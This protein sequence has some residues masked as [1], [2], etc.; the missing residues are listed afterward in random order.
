MAMA[1]QYNR[2]PVRRQR[3][4]LYDHAWRV[5]SAR[6]LAM[7]PWCVRCEARG[8]PRLAV[9]TDHTTPHR[10]DPVL[11][12]DPM[13]HQSLCKRCHDRKTRT[14]DGGGGQRTGRLTL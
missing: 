7:F 3:M 13:N 4:A 14:E 9:V 11:F 1:A 10:G 2:S 12:R 8:R 6:R 5:Y